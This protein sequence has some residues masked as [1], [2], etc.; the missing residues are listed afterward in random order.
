MNTQHPNSQ[1]NTT[2]ISIF[3]A[4]DSTTNLHTALD[5]YKTPVTEMQGMQL[6]YATIIINKHV[7]EFQ[8]NKYA[9]GVPFVSSFQEITSFCVL[10][11]DSA[12]QVV[13]SLWDH[14]Y[15]LH[16]PAN[17]L[18]GRHNCLWCLIPSSSLKVPLEVRGRFK[19]RSLDSLK[20]DHSKFLSDGGGDI[21]KAK[22]FNNVIEEYFFDIPLENVTTCNII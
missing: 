20:S 10:C 1:K 9:V 11:M 14:V 2:L 4:G 21:R 17:A 19:E 12:V 8:N 5:M 16:I 7:T 22:F 15:K 6:K 3:K 18:P 13:S